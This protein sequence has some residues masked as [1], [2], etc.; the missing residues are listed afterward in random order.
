MTVDIV[1]HLCV[2]HAALW[3]LLA[4]EES[5]RAMALRADQVA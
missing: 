5:A 3:G 1:R 4:Q 2:T